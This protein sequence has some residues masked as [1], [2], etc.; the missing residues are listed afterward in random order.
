M[1]VAGGDDVSKWVRILRL[2]HSTFPDEKISFAVTRQALFRKGC[3]L[4][5]RS[6]VARKHGAVRATRSARLAALL[7]GHEGATARRLAGWCRPGSMRQSVM[8]YWQSVISC[9]NI[10]RAAGDKSDAGSGA[11]H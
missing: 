3:G 7:G 5:G 11:I 10:L 4:S 1:G 2:K 9:S 8:I 6:G